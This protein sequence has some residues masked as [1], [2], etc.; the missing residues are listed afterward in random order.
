MKNWKR[1]TQVLLLSSLTLLAACSNSDDDDDDDTSSPTPPVSQAMDLTILH[2]NDHHSNLDSKSKT[3]LLKNAAGT[4]TE[5]TVDAG[6]FPRVT[7]AINELATASTNVL[8]LHAGDA[9]TGTLYFN[10]AGEAGEADAALMNTVCFDAMTLG[11]HEFDKGDSGLH[12]FIEFLHAGT[13]QTPLLSANVSFGPN[14]PLNAANAPNWV[15]PSITLERGGQSI[16]LIG[17]TIAGKT[18]QS[19]SPDPGTTFSDETEAAQTQIDALRAQG[20]N[21]IIVMS[22]IG[23][24]YDK[25]IIPNLSGVDVVVGGDSHSLLGPDAMETYDVGTPAG[26][27]PTELTDKD[28]KRVCLV[29]AWEYAQVVGELKVSFDANGDVTSCSGTPHVLIGDTLTVGGTT[30]NP[31][32]AAAMQADIEA[33]GILRVQAPDAN[34][35]QTL[36]PFKEQVDAYSQSVVANVPQELCSRRV[37]G[38]PGSVDYSRSS[39]ACNAEGSVNVRGGDIQ[40]LVAQAYLEVANAEY[41]GADISLQSGGGVRVP[42]EGNVTAANVIEVLPFGNMLWRLDITGTE[43]IGMLED[44]LEAVYGDG[45]TTGPYPYTGGLRYDVN[46]LAAKG[47]RV[48]NVEVFDSTTNTWQSLDATRTYKLFV[49]SFNATGGDGY[50]TL[51]NVP[52]ERRQ[53]IGVLDADVLQTYIDMQAKDANTNLPILNRLPIELYSTKNYVE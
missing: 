17:L 52:D 45:G 16:G 46:S 27:Y 13:C 36:Q 24:S 3:L 21:K 5:A 1:T 49:L 12:R 7:A 14:S 18:Q 2:I 40:Q 44:G 22:H 10:R 8:K 39:A 42:L 51:A 47:S 35:T 29:Q 11:N 26:T 50:T 53:D 37:P 6:G 41:G 30:P 20:V 31:A 33:S 4:Q 48:S 38:G 28:G 34:A 25:E 19:S 32:D 15:Q 23:Y 9:M 43:V